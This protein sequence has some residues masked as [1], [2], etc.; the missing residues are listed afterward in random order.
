MAYHKQRLIG[1]DE[2]KKNRKRAQWFSD[3]KLLWL[4]NLQHQYQWFQ[5]AA[6]ESE[7]R[8]I[9]VKIGR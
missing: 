3:Y 4:S 2:K 5:W 8:V 7:K 1:L 6:A 9:G